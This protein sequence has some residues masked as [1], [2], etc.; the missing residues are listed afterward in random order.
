MKQFDRE[1][2]KAEGFIPK[3]WDFDNPFDPKLIIRKI[4]KYCSSHPERIKNLDNMLTEQL[5]MLNKRSPK[6][7]QEIC[8]FKEHELKN[9]IGIESELIVKLRLLFILMAGVDIHSFEKKFLPTKEKQ[10]GKDKK[11]NQFEKNQK[12]D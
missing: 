1:Q 7:Y 9:I 8:D 12:Q 10:V 2:L 5:N 11:T 4:A 3:N 6:K